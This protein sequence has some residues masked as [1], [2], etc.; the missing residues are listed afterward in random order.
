MLKSPCSCFILCFSRSLGKPAGQALEGALYAL[1]DYSVCVFFYAQKSKRR[2]MLMKDISKECAFFQSAKN[3]Q[4]NGAY[5]TDLDHARRMGY[6]FDFDSA[7]EI[8]VLEASA[9]DGE[10]LLA[11]TGKLE[12]GRKHMKLFLV[13]LNENTFKERLEESILIPVQA[14]HLPMK[15][16]EQL[17]KTVGKVKRQINPK[18]EIEGILLTMVDNRTNY[19]NAVDKEK[20]ADNKSV[21]KNYLETDISPVITA[22]TRLEFQYGAEAFEAQQLEAGKEKTESNISKNI[23]AEIGKS[24]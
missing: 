6:L 12:K 21:D 11:V 4:K 10:A 17:I 2:K 15:G 18:L 14:A 1:M 5:Y 22:G 19:A 7:D 8:S 20:E 9:G 24:R 23:S 13:E 16:L 3:I